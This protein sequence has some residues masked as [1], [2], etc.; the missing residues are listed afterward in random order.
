MARTN[1]RK[2]R[3]GDTFF[4]V[5]DTIKRELEP[6]CKRKITNR[7]VTDNIGR[8]LVEENLLPHMVKNGKKR[9]GGLF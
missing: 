4:S 8:F 6:V 3:A 2:M 9:K 7:E 1:S 5:V